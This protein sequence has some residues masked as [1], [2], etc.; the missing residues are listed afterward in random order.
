MA[1]FTAGRWHHWLS[2]LEQNKDT[3]VKYVYKSEF[4]G[5]TK[6]DK[7]IDLND[8]NPDEHIKSEIWNEA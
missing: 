6:D 7:T 8:F 4:M 2:E 5:D 3:K 1:S